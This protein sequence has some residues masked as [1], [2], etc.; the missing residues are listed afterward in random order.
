MV[1]LINWRAMTFDFGKRL[2]KMALCVSPP[3]IRVKF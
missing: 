1:N 3:L 2:M